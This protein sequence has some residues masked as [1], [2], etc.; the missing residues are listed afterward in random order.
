MDLSFQT[1]TGRFNYR[2]AAVICRDGK[3]L[4]LQEPNS[5]YA[6]LP[7]GRVAMTE[8]AEEA[9]LR[10]V[11]EET[12]LQ[13]HIIRPLWLNQA[14]FTEDQTKESFHEICLYFLVDLPV[15]EA[16]DF[17]VME[18]GRAN[19]LKWIA[20]EALQ[21]TYFYPEFLKTEIFQLPKHLT[22]RVEREED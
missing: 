21:E 5:P 15:A 6:Y 8:T 18:N 14:F 10:E 12:G 19:Q 16:E 2:V 9:I 7:G 22:L 11:L 13:G 3:L 17:V 20:F 1:V 4:T